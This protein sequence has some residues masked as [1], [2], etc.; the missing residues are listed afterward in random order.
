VEDFRDPE[1]AR[2]WDV[3]PTRRNPA[4]TEQID[5][6]ISVLADEY[7]QGKAILDIGIGSGHVEE[8]LFERIPGAYVV[9]LDGSEAMVELAHKRLRAYAD[10]YEVVLHDITQIGDLELP[11][12]DI[13]AIISIQTIHN[14]A[15]EHK[16]EVFDFA[17]KALEPGGIFLLL[18]RIAVDSPHLFSAYKSLWNRMNRLRLHNA[19]MREGET[20]E[21]HLASVATRGDL[22]ITL[23]R[24]LEWLRE[25]GFEAACLH[26]HGNRALFAGRK[27]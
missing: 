2:S 14:V 9:G 3:D 26:L 6:L 12:M 20:F 23:E 27:V 19:Q 22:P 1:T 24:H 16:R 8:M 21:E 11:R 17:Y 4:R 18:D 15:D 13:Q 10:R 5:I 25:A 7:Q